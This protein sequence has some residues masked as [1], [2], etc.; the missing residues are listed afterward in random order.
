MYNFSGPGRTRQINLAG[1]STTSS[2]ETLLREARA[3]RE[4]REAEL[5]RHDS[6]TRIAVWWHAVQAAR[7]VREEYARMFDKGPGPFGGPVDWTRSL[8]VC[9][10][11]G[12]QGEARLGNWSAAFVADSQGKL[13]L[14]APFSTRDGGRWLDLLCRLSVRL[15]QAVAAS[16]GSPHTLDH[17]TVLQNLLI[18]DRMPKQLTP[19]TAQDI[20]RS[21]VTTLIPAK[22]CMYPYLNHAILSVDPKDKGLP[23]L[24]PL[25]DLALAPIS[26]LASM[27]NDTGIVYQEVIERFFAS[28]LSI[29][30]LPYRLPISAIKRISTQFPFKHLGRIDLYSLVRKLES[31]GSADEAKVELVV[32]LYTFLPIVLLARFKESE[33][34]AYLNLLAAV[35]DSLPPGALDPPKA[36]ATNT[37]AGPSTMDVDSDS[38][39]EADLPQ[40]SSSS[41]PAPAPIQLSLSPRT[42]KRLEQ[43]TE[44]AYIGALLGTSHTNADSAVCRFFLSLWAAWPGRRDAT[45]AAILALPGPA[46]AGAGTGAGANAI[47]KGIWRGRVRGAVGALGDGAGDGARNV[48]VLVDESTATLWPSLVF[49]I[50]LYTHMLRTMSDDEFFATPVGQAVQNPLSQTQSAQNPLSTSEVAHLGRA[51]LGI[52]FRLYLNDAVIGTRR[53]PGL[54]SLGF[55]M[56]RE[57]GTELL[58]GVCLRDSR[59]RFTPEG[60]WLMVDA[61]DAQQICA[62]ALL[63]EESFTS[64]EPSPISLNPF[65]TN[66]PGYTSSRIRRA[67]LA[68]L[69]PHSKVLTHIPFAIP[70]DV[71]VQVLRRFVQKDWAEVAQRQRSGESMRGRNR[72]NAVVRRG[73]VAED[74]FKAL[75]GMREELK[76]PIAITFIDQWGHEEAG[77]DGGGVFKEFLTSLAKETFDSDRGLWL[78]NKQQELYPNPHP[79]AKESGQLEWFRFVGRVLGKALYEGILVDIAFA[80]FFLAKLLGRQSYIDDLASLDPELYQGLMFLKNFKGNPE[81]LALNFTITDEYFGEVVVTNLTPNGADRPVTA[82]NRHAYILMV[83]HHRLKAQI[84]KQSDAF[85]EGLADIINPKWL[86][87]FNQQELQMLIGGTPDPID[88]DDLRANVVYGGL[89]DESHEVIRTFWKVVK[90]FNQGER[91]ALLRF[92]TSCSRP[93]LLGFKELNPRFA[94]RDATSDDQ[95]LPTAS[96][97]VNLLKLPRYSSESIMRQKVL[98]AISSNAG[99]DLS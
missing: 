24:P 62:A 81:E 71:R 36:S 85:M 77:I 7:A 69:S 2:S 5:R 93:P 28:I 16:P 19:A 14:Y 37:N 82:E 44:P 76:L 63:E 40:P 32:N 30:L 92:V 75:S 83:A 20:A 96:T 8:L 58:Q 94:I 17:L 46:G 99:F 56:I 1:S 87:M 38:D 57:W 22:T 84:R 13:S 51:L 91:R 72:A 21:V 33:R 12:V 27:G 49:L 4:A 15:L 65:S 90:D 61:S 45:L 50:V 39:S 88:L 6:A 42:R 60:H 70:F 35:F 89:Y 47:V 95:R 18:P 68:S 11:K 9:G 25:I 31:T 23:I 67:Q 34:T 80:P 97:C 86:R 79:Y 66:P 26:L 78:V 52:V 55:S 54:G 74:G 64:D 29:P 3:R 73:R 53:V 59:R 98:Q 48:E 43:L 10:T 41:I